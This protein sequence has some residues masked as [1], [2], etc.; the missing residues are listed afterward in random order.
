MLAKQAEHELVR[1]PDSATIGACDNK[2]PHAIKQQQK[3][4]AG[5]NYPQ[6]EKKTFMATK[7]SH[8]F[9]PPSPNAR[10]IWCFR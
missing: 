3:L 9:C 2:T 7:Q 5:W 8:Q 1:S 6:Q 10:S 4:R